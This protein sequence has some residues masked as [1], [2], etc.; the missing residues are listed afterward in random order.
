M[1][2]KT[3]FSPQTEDL[4]CFLFHAAV[5]IHLMSLFDACFKLHKSE[6]VPV[7]EFMYLVFTC[8]PGESDHS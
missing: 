1:Q 4:S 5:F 8:M 7:V 2:P 6:N 3:F